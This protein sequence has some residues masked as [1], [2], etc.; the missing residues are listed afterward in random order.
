[1]RQSAFIIVLPLHSLELINQVSFTFQVLRF[2]QWRPW[3]ALR[4]HL[5]PR[6][7]K[8]REAADLEAIPATVIAP[9]AGAEGSGGTNCTRQN[10][11]D[12]LFFHIVCLKQ[13]QWDRNVSQ[14]RCLMT[15]EE[16]AETLS[17][18]KHSAGRA[19]LASAYATAPPPL[20]APAGDAQDN[21]CQKFATLREKGMISEGTLAFA[22]AMGF[23]KLSPVQEVVIPTLVKGQQDV[24]VEACTGSGKTLAFLIP[25]VEL[26]LR[27]AK[28]RKAPRGVTRIGGLCLAPTR[29]LAIQINSVL[30]SYL[31]HVNSNESPIIKNVLLTGGQDMSHTVSALAQVPHGPNT[32]LSAA[33][34]P[35]FIL[36][37]T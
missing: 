32:V 19:A 34:A 12:K 20:G 18:A 33:P 11:S 31:T 8:A 24:A 7:V 14:A 13:L 2:P 21:S 9:Y 37:A 3:N 4:K 35:W 15:D 10:F 29:E 17:K 6:S 36:T 23:V 28:E 27:K 16:S 26:L 25:C 1:M 22:N 30:D 5:M